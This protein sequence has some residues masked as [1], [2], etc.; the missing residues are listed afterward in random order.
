MGT[1]LLLP[2]TAITAP[3]FPSPRLASPFAWA[4]VLYQALAGA[5]AHVWWYRAV[6]I[7]GP[8]RSAMFMNLQPVVGIA[9]AA[10]LL[11]EPLTLWQ[12][13]GGTFV[14]AGVGLTTR[15]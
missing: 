1:L 9:L 8:S 4:V 12:L 11:A 14:L 10:L 3:F 6:E 13:I 2:V 7:V 15:R 5:V